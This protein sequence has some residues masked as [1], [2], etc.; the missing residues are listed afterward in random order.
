MTCRLDIDL[1]SCNMFKHVW[2]NICANGKIIIG[3]L[4]QNNIFG[5]K[6]RVVE[7]VKRSSSTSSSTSSR[8][9]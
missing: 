2:K 6:F 9:P 7:E 5:A 8:R 1:S 4:L 3:K